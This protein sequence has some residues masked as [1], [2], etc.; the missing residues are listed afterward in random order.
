MEQSLNCQRDDLM[1]II[2][3]KSTKLNTESAQLSDVEKSELKRIINA[4]EMELLR[5]NDKIRRG[6]T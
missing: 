2:Q 5:V 4:K 1:R 3:E 6:D